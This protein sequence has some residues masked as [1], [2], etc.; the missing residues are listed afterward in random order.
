MSRGELER[1]LRSHGC[2][3]MREG[4]RHTI[5]SNP[6]LGRTAAVPR[7]QEIKRNTARRIC[8]DLGIPR[9]PSL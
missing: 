4:S 7:H 5:W 8:D 1:H 6:A 2:A 3:A 9:H